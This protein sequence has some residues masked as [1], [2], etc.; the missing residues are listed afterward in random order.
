MDLQAFEKSH[1]P[2]V[3]D[4]AHAQDGERA[5]RQDADD[6]IDGVSHG[7]RETF[8]RDLIRS[9]YHREILVATQQVS[10]DYLAVQPAE[11]LGDLRAISPA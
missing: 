1:D 4:V 11:L 10:Y 5:C 8:A 2:E 3:V 7:G 6:A 9:D